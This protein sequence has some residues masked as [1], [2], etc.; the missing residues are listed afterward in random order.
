LI[1]D[2]YREATGAILNP[3]IRLPCITPGPA[4]FANLI[5]LFFTAANAQIWPRALEGF[6]GGESLYIPRR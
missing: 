3:H 4:Q 5:L 1:L 6:I 2:R